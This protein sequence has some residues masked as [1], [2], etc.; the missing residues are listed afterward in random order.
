MTTRTTKTTI[1]FTQPFR[2]G[3][4]GESFPP[5]VYEVETDEE[6]LEGLSF[7][8]YRATQTL[9]YVPARPRQTGL[10]RPLKV[11]AAELEAAQLRDAAPAAPRGPDP[12]TTPDAPASRV[13]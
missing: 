2:I 13:A 12:D 8:A 4:S 3:A 11:D 7:L 5:G 9:L 1:R 6:L 10:F